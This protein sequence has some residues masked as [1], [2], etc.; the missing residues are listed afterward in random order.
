M[1]LLVFAPLLAVGRRVKAGLREFG[2]AG[3]LGKKIM[4]IQ[5]IWEKNQWDWIRDI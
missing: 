5:D 2:D 3:Y 1:G 4:G